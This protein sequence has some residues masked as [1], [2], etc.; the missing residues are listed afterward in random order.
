LGVR[1]VLLW[2]VVP[3]VVVVWLLT[4]P[5]WHRQQVSLRQ[6][7]GW[8]D[9]NLIAALQRSILRSLVQRPLRRTPRSELPNVRHRIRLGDPA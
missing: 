2:L 6:L 1:G 4:W 5:V 9:L 7:L 8:A 3:L